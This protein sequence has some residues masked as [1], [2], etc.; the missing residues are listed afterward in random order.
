MGSAKGIGRSLSDGSNNSII[1]KSVRLP[2]Y[3][4]VDSLD[5]RI[6][7]INNDRIVSAN[8]HGKDR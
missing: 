1:V 5:E 8:I 4:T 7:W 3:L 2:K 6:Y